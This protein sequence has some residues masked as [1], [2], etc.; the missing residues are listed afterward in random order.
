MELDI[1]MRIRLWEYLYKSLNNEQVELFKLYKKM[2]EDM[3]WQNGELLTASM[4]LDILNSGRIPLDHKKQFTLIPLDKRI[5]DKYSIDFPEPIIVD[6][7]FNLSTTVMDI[8]NEISDN[9]IK[10]IMLNNIDKWN[11]VTVQDLI[12]NKT[13]F[14]ISKQCNYNI[15]TNITLYLHILDRFYPMEKDILPFVIE[16]RNLKKTDEEMIEMAIDQSISEEYIP[17]ELLCPISRQLMVDPVKVETGHIFDR[18]SIQRWFNTG[19]ITNPMTN[20]H[21]KSLYLLSD[22][23]LR[24][25]CLHYVKRRIKPQEFFEKHFCKIDSEELYNILKILFECISSNTKMNSESLQKRANL[26]R[27]AFLVD[28]GYIYIL[29]CVSCT[30]YVKTPGTNHFIIQG[31]KFGGIYLSYKS[32]SKWKV[33]S[34]NEQEYKVFQDDLRSLAELSSGEWDI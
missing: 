26:K 19:K 14:T 21:L 4:F 24:N 30:I 7:T 20:K 13:D 34:Y 3:I 5:Y 22:K 15:A 8:V 10:D 2:Q 29:G 31:R 11:L 6:I 17:E 18:H 33:L 27:E 23:K 32:P 12:L 25:R 1:P 28:N 16:T 9:N